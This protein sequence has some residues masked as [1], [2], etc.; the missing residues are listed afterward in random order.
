MERKF[1][2]EVDRRTCVVT[3]IEVALVVL[4]LFLR[5]K[6]NSI[7]SGGVLVI[8]GIGIYHTFMRYFKS[9]YMVSDE[10]IIVDIFS[11]EK[12]TYPIDMITMIVYIDTVSKWHPFSRQPRHQLAIF[13]KRSF[14]KS[15]EPVCFAPQN[16]DA[17]VDAILTSNPDITVE[18]AEIKYRPFI[19]A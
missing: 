12:R 4:W 6:L 8:L 5:F 13:F 11:D 15:I 7:A 16:R 14:I 18:I 9:G 19:F 17:F 3:L 1:R 2:I 10:E